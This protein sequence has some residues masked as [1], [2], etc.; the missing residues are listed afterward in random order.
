M[1][2]ASAKD[3]ATIGCFFDDQVTVLLEIS[4]INPPTQ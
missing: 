1:Y 4:K 2:S 3:I